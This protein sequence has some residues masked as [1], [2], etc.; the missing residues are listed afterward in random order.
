MAA[1]LYVPVADL[2]TAQALSRGVQKLSQPDAVRPADYVTEFAFN[3]IVDIYPRLAEFAASAR[4][5]ASLLVSLDRLGFPDGFA[6]WRRYSRKLPLQ[7]HREHSAGWRGE[8]RR[9]FY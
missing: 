2:E 4:R 8:Y 9:K 1:M 3:W 7:H 6:A 5:V